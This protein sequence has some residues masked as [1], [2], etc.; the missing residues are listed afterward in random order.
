[1][2][3]LFTVPGKTERKGHR[4]QEQFIA[5]KYNESHH[6]EYW[7]DKDSEI[8]DNKNL[9][10]HEVR[11]LINKRRNRRKESTNLMI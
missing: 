1:M 9:K 4:N 6:Q 10:E 2:P 5:H 8:R 3:L 11:S 7:K